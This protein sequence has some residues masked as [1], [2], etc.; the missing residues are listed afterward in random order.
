MLSK[1]VKIN[2]YIIALLSKS[3]L[4]VISR[5]AKFEIDGTNL[6]CLNQ[7][8]ELIFINAR[9]NGPNIIIEKFRF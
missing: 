1:K 2:D 8:K 5:N 3:Y 4:T 6:T 9:L 7:Q